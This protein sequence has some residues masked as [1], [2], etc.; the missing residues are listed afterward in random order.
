MF[1]LNLLIGI[2]AYVLIA[3]LSYQIIYAVAGRRKSRPVQN[4]APLLAGGWPF[5]LP[6]IIIIPLLIKIIEFGLIVLAP[7]ME[8]IG[9]GVT[10][11]VDFVVPEAK[12]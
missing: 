3:M 7:P 6:V 11:I 9:R 12:S 8:L 10:R 5:G 1:I 4:I 2:V